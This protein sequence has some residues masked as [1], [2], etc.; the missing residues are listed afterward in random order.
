[1]HICFLKPCKEIF[2]AGL[3]MPSI[4]GVQS[5]RKG[6]ETGSSASDLTQSISQFINARMFSLPN[7]A[8]L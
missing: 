1:M 8:A 5:M 2:P 3:S 6:R 7:L 4:R